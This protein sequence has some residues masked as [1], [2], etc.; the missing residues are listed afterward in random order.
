MLAAQLEQ[1]ALEAADA[2]LVLS[3]LPLVGAT[4]AAQW[5]RHTAATARPHELLP[6]LLEWVP[7][8]TRWACFAWPTVCRATACYVAVLV[9]LACLL[10]AGQSSKRVWLALEFG[11]RPLPL[12]LGSTAALPVALLYGLGGLHTVRYGADRLAACAVLG[13]ASGAS[14]LAVLALCTLAVRCRTL[15]D[16]VTPWSDL[17]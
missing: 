2:A 16:Q 12:L 1:L 5:L 3:A 13:M 14:A 8:A 17:A 6:A 4:C 11:T 15:A 7:T 10:L 9:V